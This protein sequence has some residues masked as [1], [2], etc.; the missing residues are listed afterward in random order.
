MCLSHQSQT[1]LSVPLHKQELGCWEEIVLMDFR[2]VCWLC[3]A[4]ADGFFPWEKSSSISFTQGCTAGVRA[5]PSRSGGDHAVP[6][7]PSIPPAAAALPA[8]PSW[9]ARLGD[10]GTAG[11]CAQQGG[12]LTGLIFSRLRLALT[13]DPHY[14]KDAANAMS[15]GAGWLDLVGRGKSTSWLFRPAGVASNSNLI[16]P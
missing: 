3:P 15:P 13:C 8:R 11:A 1:H 5:P 14:R 10:R 12:E 2:G 9:Q 6:S 16:S 4:S 7:D